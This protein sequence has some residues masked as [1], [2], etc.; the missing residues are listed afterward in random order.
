VLRRYLAR[1]FAHPSGLAGRYWI[2]P[3]LDRIAAPMNRL[4]LQRLAP[5]RGE[6][7]LEVGI[8]GGALLRGLAA[9]GAEA[10]GVD[11]SE[12]MVRRARARGLRAVRGRVS[13]LPFEAARFDKAVSVNSLYFWPDPKRGFAELARVVKPGGRLAIAFE[14]AEELRQ[15]PGHRFGFRLYQVDEVRTLME[16]AGFGAIEEAWGAGRKPDRFCCLSGT[17]GG[18]NG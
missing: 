1:Q 8:G 7:I 4:A 9:A 3:W 10:W 5:R 14:P 17:R 18:A 16:S 11:P 2:G 12:P 13:D 15:W 6:A